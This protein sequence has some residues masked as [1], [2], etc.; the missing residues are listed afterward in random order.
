MMAKYTVIL[1]ALV[2]GA[3]ATNVSPIQK[4]VQLIDG[5]AAKV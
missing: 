1:A 5:L 4:T 3:A 2:G